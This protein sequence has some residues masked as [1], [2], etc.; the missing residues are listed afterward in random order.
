MS[1]VKV[2]F[3]KHISSAQGSW[4]PGQVVEL[5]EEFAKQICT[6]VKYAD[7][8]ELFVKAILYS[9]EEEA[10]LVKIPVESLTVADMMELG[11]RNVVK[12]PEDPEYKKFLQEAGAVET[13][14]NAET[15][16]TRLES[17]QKATQSPE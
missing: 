15:R 16:K 12:T 9:K 10:G 3:L 7:R 17:R 11:V 4:E 1:K 8:D 2:K 6:P 14:K 5:D 13:K